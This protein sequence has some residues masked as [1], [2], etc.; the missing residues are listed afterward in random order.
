MHEVI[1]RLTFLDTKAPEDTVSVQEDLVADPVEFFHTIKSAWG[2][3]LEDTVEHL[4][5]SQ[6]KVHKLWRLTYGENFNAEAKML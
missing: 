4:S 2:E 1:N 3:L 6:M 5:Q